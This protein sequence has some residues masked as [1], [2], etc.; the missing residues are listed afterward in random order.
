MFSTA[1]QFSNVTKATIDAQLTAMTELATKAFSSVAEVVNLNVSAA[2]ASL[3]HSSTAA[4][5]IL[6]AKDPQAFFSLASAQAQPNAEKALAYSR[7]LADIATKAQAEFTKAAE[8]RLAETTRHLSTLIDDLSKSAPA[9]SENAIAMLKTTIA[10]ANAGY[11][12]LSKATKHAS[13]TME[14]NL[15]QMVK[16]FV[17]AAEKPARAKK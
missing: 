1:D 2:K 16:Q 8:L 10:N 6:S 14:D 11:E 12:Q 15:N 17:P 9:G 4:Q 5:Q 7:H 13:E 3:E